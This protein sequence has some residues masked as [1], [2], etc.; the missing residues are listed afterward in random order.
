[1]IGY[2]V[3]NSEA[4]LFQCSFDAFPLDLLKTWLIEEPRDLVVE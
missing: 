1:M 2:A 3:S 4:E